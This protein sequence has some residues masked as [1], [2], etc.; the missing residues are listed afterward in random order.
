MRLDHP[1]IGDARAA[2]QERRG[3]ARGPCATRRGGAPRRTASEHCG[4]LS[5]RRARL[6][7]VAASRMRLAVGSPSVGAARRR[8]RKEAAHHQRLGQDVRRRLGPDRARVGD[9]GRKAE[10]EYKPRRSAARDM[11]KLNA[12]EAEEKSQEDAGDDRRVAGVV[13]R[14]MMFATVDYRG[15]LREE[16]RRRRRGVVDEPARVDGAGR[17]AVRDR[18]RREPSRRALGFHAHE[19]KTAALQQPETVA[20]EWNQHRTP[21]PAARRVE[22]EERGGEG[23]VGGGEGAGARRRRRRRR[24]PR[25]SEGEGEGGEAKKGARAPTVRRWSCERSRAE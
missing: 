10:G 18:G 8:R 3:A 4:A 13:G 24:R 12:P 9:G 23:G 1:P 21:G 22:G 20:V 14:A 17:E 15:A 11:S 6:R 2:A 25:R 16:E 19:I 5:A 7:H